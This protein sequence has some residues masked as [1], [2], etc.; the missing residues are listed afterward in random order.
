MYGKIEIRDRKGKMSKAKVFAMAKKLN[1]E[2][3][4]ERDYIEAVAPTGML[5]GDSQHHSGY[6]IPDYRKGEIWKNLEY[7]LSQITICQ[8]SRYCNC[9]EGWKE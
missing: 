5:I 4:I 8:G 7:D 2:I 6:G 9:V 1:C 3:V